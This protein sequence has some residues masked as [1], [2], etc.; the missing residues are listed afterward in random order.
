LLVVVVVVV[1]VETKTPPGTE[2][3][4]CV[5]WVLAVFLFGFALCKTAQRS[6]FR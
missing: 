3:G 2:V 1:V 4:L 5:V 6:K